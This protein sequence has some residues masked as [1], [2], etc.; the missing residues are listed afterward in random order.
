MLARCRESDPTTGEMVEMS[1]QYF[2]TKPGGT[3]VSEECIVTLQSEV[4]PPPHEMPEQDPAPI[5][6]CNVPCPMKGDCTSSI[7]SLRAWRTS[8]GSHMLSNSSAAS[9]Q[10]PAYSGDAGPGRVQAHPEAGWRGAQRYVDHHS[11]P[12]PGVSLAHFPFF[13]LHY[14]HVGMQY[15]VFACMPCGVL[16][17]AQVAQQGRAQ[18][19]SGAAWHHALPAREPRRPCHPHQDPLRQPAHYPLRPGCASGWPCSLACSSCT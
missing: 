13:A 12:V 3:E 11:L 5:S 17:W 18:E 8:A 1:A 19:H 16:C 4:H 15:R 7:T 10:C 9:S 14:M 6:L 2:P